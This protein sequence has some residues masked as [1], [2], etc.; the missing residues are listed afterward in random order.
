MTTPFVLRI[1]NEI[2]SC[3]AEIKK[4]QDT[5][6]R[7]LE[8][9]K[10][11]SP[12][13]YDQ[14]EKI[15]NSQ[16]NTNL[17]NLPT[18]LE[19]PAAVPNNNNDPYDLTV[20]QDEILQ[21][22]NSAYDYMMSQLG[23]ETVE[24]RPANLGYSL[25]DTDV[26][27]NHLASL[28]KQMDDETDAPNDPLDDKYKIHVEEV[29]EDDTKL[30]EAKPNDSKCENNTNSDDAKPEEIIEEELIEEII[31]I[32]GAKVDNYVKKQHDDIELI[33]ERIK[34]AQKAA[35]PKQEKPVERKE[36]DKMNKL[37]LLTEDEQTELYEHIYSTAKNNVI[38]TVGSRVSQM[39]KKEFDAL[40]RKEC[41]GLLE[42]AMSRPGKPSL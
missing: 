28:M 26:K 9:V 40:V 17:P 13:T 37:H 36:V 22:R 14:I 6:N 10:I 21:R 16:K 32:D 8:I 24:S 35:V 12:E 7:L 25:E 39:D 38:K 19:N 20:G 4:W 27:L 18:I 30:E 11:Q 29:V 2:N 31:E 3:Q 5:T 1:L 33:K 15:A 42:V 23:K 34:K 41:D